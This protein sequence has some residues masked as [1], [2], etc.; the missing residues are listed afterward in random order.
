M[1]KARES[2]TLAVIRQGV[3]ASQMSSAQRQLATSRLDLAARFIDDGASLRA[4]LQPGRLVIVDVRDEFIEKEQA[5]GLFVKML[6]VFSGAVGTERFNKLIIFDEAHKYMGSGPLIN[7]VVEVI[8]QMRHKGVSVVVASQDPINVPAPVIELSS[9]VCLHRFNSPNWLKHLQRS[10]AAL[11][12]LTPQ[13]MQALG[14]G[15]AFV[16]ASKA[17]DPIYTRRGVRLRIRPRA[18]KHGGSTRRASA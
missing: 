16:W 8:R 2:L 4:A 1:R 18:S 9:I 6:N 12:E 11:G 17:T 7:H 13:M 5:L 15:E 10:V 3:E 14:P